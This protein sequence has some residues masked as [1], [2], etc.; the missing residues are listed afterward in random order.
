[1]SRTS[2][3]VDLSPSRLE[4]AVVTRAG[5]QTVRIARAT[6][7]EWSE[8]SRGLGEV[9]KALG[10]TLASWVHELGLER[11]PCTLTYQA[12]SGAAG[13]FDC[14]A[15]VGASGARAAAL[16]ALGSVASFPIADEPHDAVL[17]HADRVP[18]PATPQ[19]PTPQRQVHLLGVVERDE[20]VV[21]LSAWLSGAGLGPARL[22]PAPALELAHAVHA[23][24]SERACSGVLWVGDHA[25][26]LAVGDR[27][28]LRF[29]RTLGPGVE[30]LVD[31]LLRAPAA[32]AGQPQ[33]GPLDRAAAR[34]LLAQVG[35]PLGG[36]G[37]ATDS[38]AGGGPSLLALLTP[39]LQRLG[40]EIKQSVRF[41]LAEGERQ[42]LVITLMGPGGALKN[43][44]EAL[45]QQSGVG[46]QGRAVVGG[47]LGESGSSA[48]AGVLALARAGVLPGFTLAPR[49]AMAA[50]RFVQV[51][52]AVGV[53]AAAALALVGWQALEVRAQERALLDDAARVQSRDASGEQLSQRAQAALAAERVL[54]ERLA[55]HLGSTSDFA[56]VLALIAD[57]CPKAMRLVN[58]DLS[59][60][61]GGPQ[62]QLVGVISGAGNDPGALVQAL[63]R[64]TDRLRQNPLV[65]GVQMGSSSRATDEQG[66]AGLR[67]ELT[68]RLVAIPG[69]ALV[70]GA[71]PAT[72]TALCTPVSAGGVAPPP[73]R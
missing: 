21:M 13:V 6:G 44:S 4:L 46:V 49:S 57:E 2:V 30:T 33:A 22:V 8:W 16:L 72:T 23:V 50:R 25:S 63:S 31:A 7:P 65:A 59:A 34:D 56:A 37:A 64:F 52:R 55:A 5:V 73:T 19:A 43:L 53:G 54:H 66:S 11:A 32:P 27:G 36:L 14:P 71:D 51:R 1:M 61:Q 42:G 67:F 58:V 18:P 15:S 20:S 45:A 69:V 48:G 70:P 38:G 24:A 28:R 62:A 35:I 41:G 3:F 39:V 17:L 9:L 12:N 29:V 68:L 60:E 26:V 47:E 40:S 10:S